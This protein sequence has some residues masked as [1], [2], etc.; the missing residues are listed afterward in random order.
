MLGRVIGLQRLRLAQVEGFVD[1]S[2]ARE[3]VPVD[4]GDGG[5]GLP[6]APGAAD[7]VDIR[8]FVFG[9]LVVDDVGDVVD[10]DASGRDVGGDED[11]DLAVAEGPERLLA[12]A[13][14]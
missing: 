8:F 5:P 3:V 14:A 11:V 9:A 10:V 13:L 2:P 4:K 1:E 7:T 6:C 12:R